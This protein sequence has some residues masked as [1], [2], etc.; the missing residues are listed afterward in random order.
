ML[1]H[2]LQVQEL[3]RGII[4]ESGDGRGNRAPGLGAEYGAFLPAER[5]SPANRQPPTATRSEESSIDQ[6]LSRRGW[7][8]RTDGFSPEGPSFAPM[9][10]VEYEIQR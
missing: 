7:C 8:N 1:H 5:Y 4:T 3:H 2:Y 9:K 6:L 10:Q